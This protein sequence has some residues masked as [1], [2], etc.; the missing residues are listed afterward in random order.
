MDPIHG[1]ALKHNQSPPQRHLR[2]ENNSSLVESYHSHDQNESFPTL[3][4][5][6]HA[7]NHVHSCGSSVPDNR[8]I[9]STEIQIARDRVAI[10]M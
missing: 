1:K 9:C 8:S 10:K 4:E 5:L 2:Q 6:S 7:L 3:N